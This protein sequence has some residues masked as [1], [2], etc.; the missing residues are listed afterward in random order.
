MSETLNI[1]GSDLLVHPSHFLGTQTGSSGP[2]G[3]APTQEL[4]QGTGHSEFHTRLGW[5][6]VL[7]RSGLGD[8]GKRVRRGP[9]EGF[10]NDKRT[11]DESSLL[12]GCVC[13][14]RWVGCEWARTVIILGF[15]SSQKGK[16]AT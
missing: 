9:K 2:E 6:A 1:R 13:D 15:P 14:P 4:A 10:I 16:K 3:G 12:L 7:C 5:A 11:L 8:A